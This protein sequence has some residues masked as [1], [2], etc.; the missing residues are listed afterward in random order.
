MLDTFGR[1]IMALSNSSSSGYWASCRRWEGVIAFLVIIDEEKKK[2]ADVLLHP[3]DIE[4]VLYFSLTVPGVRITEKNR[5]SV[6]KLARM[7]NARLP[8]IS[9]SPE[10]G[11]GTLFCYY[12]WR[13]PRIIDAKEFRDNVEEI[14]EDFGEVMRTFHRYFLWLVRG[15][16]SLEDLE[17]LLTERFPLEGGPPRLS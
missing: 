16:I 4:P 17:K 2:T 8:Y 7:V 13:Y 9:I 1:S 6:G 11:D 12:V 10:T 5:E 3:H 14:T 15:K